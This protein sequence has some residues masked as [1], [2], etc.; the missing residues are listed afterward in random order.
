MTL[1]RGLE[2]WKNSICLVGGLTPRYLVRARPPD[3]PPHA[4]TQDVDIV[5]DLHDPMLF[6]IYRL[7]R[8]GRSV[9]R[10]V[11]NVNDGGCSVYASMVAS[12]LERAG[13]KAWG[14]V[15]GPATA[16]LDR[17]REISSPRSWSLLRAHPRAVRAL[18]NCI[19][20]GWHCRCERCTHAPD[21]LPGSGAGPFHRLGVSA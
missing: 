14:V 2:P 17:A 9:Q 8:C 4:G 3:V 11:P 15:M 1:L 19:G 6:L 21:S 16:Y 7:K 12:A 10:K 5:I 13:I 18:H 20:A